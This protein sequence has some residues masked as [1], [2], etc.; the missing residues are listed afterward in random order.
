MNL[1]SSS[2]LELSALFYAII[3]VGVVAMNAVPAIHDA[4]GLMF[5]L[6]KLD[7]IDDALH[8][9][10]ALWAG[11]AGLHSVGWSGFY[12]RWFGIA[13]FLDGLSGVVLGRG[14]LDGALWLSR[15][16]I[17]PLITRIEANIPHLLLGGIALLLGYVMAKR[18]VWTRAR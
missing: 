4:N 9:A 11:I 14:F 6:F 7:L 16:P 8:I 15:D 17:A 10:S 18:K 2:R 3:F 12:F 13:Y 5:G 1:K